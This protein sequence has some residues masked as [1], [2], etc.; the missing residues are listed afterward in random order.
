MHLRHYLKK[1]SSKGIAFGGGAARGFAHIGVIKVLQE[2][3]IHFDQISGNSAG[4]IVGALYAAGKSWQEMYDFATC[5]KSTNLLSINFKTSGLFSS[6]PIEKMMIEILGDIEFSDLKHPFKII[7]V[8]LLTGCPVI[9]DQGP[10]ARAVRA[11]CSV[12]GI[13]SPTPIDNMLL[14]DGGLLNSVPG[15]IVRDMGAKFVVGV[16]LNADR[17]IP[18][19]PKSGGDTLLAA[20]N[21]IMNDNTKRGLAQADVLIEPDL[22]EFTYRDFKNVERLVQKGEEAAWRQLPDI[23][24]AFRKKDIIRK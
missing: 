16:N 11:S 12:P 19:Q 13:L 7:A 5:L 15:D 14:V 22:K 8:D 23:L 21:I 2:T 10:V 18:F 24:T 9:L 17:G 4:S 1:W 3:G 20:F 6:Q